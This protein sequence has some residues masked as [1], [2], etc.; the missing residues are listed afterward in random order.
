MTNDRSET[1]LHVVSRGVLEHSPEE[2][3]IGIAR[4]LLQHAVD[5]HAQDLDHDTPL[6]SAAFS[7][8]LEIVRA[9][10]DHGA[11]VNAENKEGR[12]PLHQAAQGKYGTKVNGVDI[13]RLLLERG[14]D[15]NARTKDKF[16]PLHLAAFCG[17][18]EVARVLLENGANAKAETECGDTPLHIVSRGDYDSQ[19]D[20]VGIA[21]LLLEY[22]VDVDAPNKNHYTALHWTAFGERLQITQL[23]LDHGANPNV[24]TEQGGTPLVLL[25]ASEGKCDC[26]EHGV[27]IARLLLDRGAD[28]NAHMKD[29]FTP[30][31]WAAFN[32]R[33][34]IAQVLLFFE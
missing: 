30:L 11:N 26:P 31:H 21:R 29:M 7:G 1:P 2:N 17:R 27:A 15:V 24:E 28:V 16:T 3:G 13:T 20:G 19:E 22:N 12:T 18:F 23:L 34:H 8:M 5:L 25:V 14:V 9:L 32:G 4:L 33:L 10:L 6:H